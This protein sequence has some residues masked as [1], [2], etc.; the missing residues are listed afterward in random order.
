MSVGEN[1]YVGGGKSEKKEEVFQYNTSQDEW[2]RLP[3]HH[4]VSFAM[5]Q[6]ARSLITVGGLIP[7]SGVTGKVYHFKEESQEWEEFLKPMPTARCLL[8]VATTQSV[9]IA[10]G[11]VTGL[12]DGKNAACATVEVYSS[13]TSQWYTADPLPV[14]CYTMTSTIL[15]DT[16][17]LLGGVD[18]NK[19]GIPTVLYTSLTSLVQKATSPTPCQSA[20]SFW[21]TL[22]N[23]PLL[24]SAAA[25]LSGSILAV[26][27]GDGDTQCISSAVHVFLPFTNS[28]VR[29]TDGDLP[30]P[31][32]VCTAEQLSSNAMLVIG[33]QRSSRTVFIGTVTVV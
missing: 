31:R 25:N 30:E 8:N 4:V 24:T 6:F 13:A 3:P 32:C 27:G 18:A 14:S 9:I 5:A 28:W 17:Y 26:G 7:G 15:A 16:Y 22:P 21:K 19:N 29:V 11:G 23:T 12:R 1:V 33:G 2:S 20:R 10:S